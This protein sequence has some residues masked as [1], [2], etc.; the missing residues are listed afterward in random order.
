MLVKAILLGLVGVLGN[1]DSRFLGRT[2]LEQPLVMGAFV[3]LVL[4]DL[5]KGLIVG[6]SLELVFMG[7]ANIGAAAPPDLVLGSVIATSFAILSHTNAQTALTIAL[8]V[9]IL[10][11]MI[12]I[13]LRMFMSTFNRWAAADI[14]AGKFAKARRLHILWGLLLNVSMYFILIFLSIYFGTGVVKVVVKAIPTWLTNALTLAS[15]I[16]P[17]FGFALLMQTMLT[18]KTVVYLLIGFFITAYGNLS[19]IAVAIFAVL[20]VLVLNE[21]LPKKN[22]ATTTEQ[23]DDDLEEL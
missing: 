15:K 2:N 12:G 18:K 21:I 20:L 6:A 22:V 23:N 10:G 7:M 11:Q 4:G 19:V 8:P 5:T 3:G 1:L 16:L 14:D 13:V 9:A 17:A